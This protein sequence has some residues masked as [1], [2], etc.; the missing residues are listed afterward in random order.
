MDPNYNRHEDPSW[1][2][3]NTRWDPCPP[4]QGRGLRSLLRKEAAVLD[5]KEATEHREP[6]GGPGA[7]GSYKVKGLAMRL[8]QGV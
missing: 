5:S 8:V 2:L 7:G 4:F 6:E 3:G 1:E